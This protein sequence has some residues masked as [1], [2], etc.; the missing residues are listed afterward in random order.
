M[1]DR[2]I[3]Q[4]IA[5]GVAAILI[6]LLLVAADGMYLY[7]TDG[8]FEEAINYPVLNGRTS[9][10]FCEIK[11][12]DALNAVTHHLS[13]HTTTFETTARYDICL[14]AYCDRNQ[15]WKIKITASDQNEAFFFLTKDYYVGKHAQC[16]TD[17]RK[18]SWDLSPWRTTAKSFA[19]FFSIF[20]VF[21]VVFLTNLAIGMFGVIWAVFALMGPRVT[22]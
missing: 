4:R 15:T 6:F 16:Y 20:L 18:T 14:R 8:L 13:T 22:N 10:G 2:Q 5:A 12:I 11:E 17:G 21:T 19:Y 3:P 1:G 7:S 9:E